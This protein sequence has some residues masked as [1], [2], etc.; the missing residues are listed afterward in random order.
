MQTGNPAVVTSSSWVHASPDRPPAMLL[1]G[2]RHDVVV[3]DQASLPSDTILTHSIAR[4]GVVQLRRWGLLDEVL[5]SGAPPI[6]QVT[7]HAGG[8]AV[9]RTIKH[10]AGGGLGGGA[11]TVRAGHHPGDRRGAG[12]R[13]AA[14]GRHRDRCPAG[15]PRPG[16][17]CGRSGP[18][19]HA[20][21]A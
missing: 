7:F 2:L 6:R 18:A 9:S 17:G 21:G 19:R 4:R 14:L 5:D 13:P 1:A 3:V 15:R 16:G 8:Q 11:A 12:R 20:G 10:K